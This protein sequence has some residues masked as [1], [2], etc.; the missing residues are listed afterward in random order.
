[1]FCIYAIF[2]ASIQECFLSQQRLHP[3]SVASFHLD[4]IDNV[5]LRESIMRQFLSIKEYHY[6]H[7]S[8]G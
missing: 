7:S 5:I 6:F 8:G 3:P 1:M 2:D 4:E